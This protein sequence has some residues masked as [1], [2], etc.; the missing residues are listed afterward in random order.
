MKTAF[1]RLPIPRLL[2]SAIER[3]H[4][5]IPLAGVL[6]QPESD[7]ILLFAK[8]PETQIE[9][10]ENLTSYWPWSFLCVQ[11]LSQVA[12]HNP[13]SQRLVLIVWLSGKIPA[14]DGF[15]LAFRY[16]PPTG[17]FLP[18]SRLSNLTVRPEK[19]T[20]DLALPAHKV[21]EPLPSKN[22]K[23][24]LAA[25]RRKQ[26][27]ALKLALSLR[28][29]NVVSVVQDPRNGVGTLSITN[30]SLR[31]LLIHKQW[32]LDAVAETGIDLV[33]KE[34]EVK[35][36]RSK[37]R[38]VH[39]IVK[40]PIDES[41]EKSV[42]SRFLLE[43]EKKI[44]ARDFSTLGQ[45]IR[46]LTEDPAFL[47]QVHIKRFKKRAEHFNEKTSGRRGRPHKLAV[48]GPVAAKLERQ[49][50]EKDLPSNYAPAT[51]QP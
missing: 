48:Y 2:A 46:S 22:N 7:A 51:S 4:K 45:E 49:A 12:V 17:I 42:T 36:Y 10:L 6:Y 29:P 23:P 35:K 3:S 14:A 13:S 19:K 1:I 8:D 30:T 37:V 39:Y 27:V 31:T 18:T 26:N 16:C 24:K 21:S 11:V 20:F 50:R 33:A 34:W 44:L 41:D 38:G 9:D 15:T 28:F 40:F 43:R 5:E 32:I 25:L 47:K